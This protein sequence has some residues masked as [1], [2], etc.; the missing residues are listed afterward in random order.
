MNHFCSDVNLTEFLKDEHVQLKKNAKFR[1]WAF[2]YMN[3]I[4]GELNSM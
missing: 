1:V 4:E 3:L 2:L